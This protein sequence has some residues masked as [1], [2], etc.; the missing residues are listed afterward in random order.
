MPFNSVSNWPLK[1][2]KV[3]HE[4]A[5][6]ACYYDLAFCKLDCRVAWLRLVQG[7]LPNLAMTL[8]LVTQSAVNGL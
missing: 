7:L 8:M 5:L 6:K 1:L 2:G 4:F 3:S